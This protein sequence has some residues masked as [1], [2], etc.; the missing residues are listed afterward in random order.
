M[1]KIFKC[2]W[3]TSGNYFIRIRRIRRK[4]FSVF[5]EYDE[6]WVVCEIAIHKFVSEYAKS[7]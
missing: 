4:Y 5:E 2:P 6:D 7:W 3:R 1:E